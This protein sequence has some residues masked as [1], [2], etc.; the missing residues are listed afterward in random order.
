MNK[1]NK[2]LIFDFD[3]TL[4]K[5]NLY[6]IY[7]R[8]VQKLDT[9]YKNDQNRRMFQLKHFNQFDRMRALFKILIKKYNFRIC[10]ASFGYK[11]MIDKF[12]DLSFGYD[13]I[14]KDDIIGTNGITANPND[15]SK[16]SV[17]P[18]FAVSY[19]CCYNDSGVCKNHIIMYFMNKYGTRDVIFFDDD[20]NNIV[21]AEHVCDVVWI[22]PQGS[23]GV[24][25]VIRAIN[26]SMVRNAM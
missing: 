18:R 17:D 19:P 22:N 16:S 23:L 14:D 21:Q 13:M 5:D 11:H 2:L 15:K 25:K 1:P 9:F 12:I 10:I 24:K 4:S 3:S 7:G 6:L 8:D 26:A 20:K